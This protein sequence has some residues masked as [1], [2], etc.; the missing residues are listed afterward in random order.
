MRVLLLVPAL[1]L[2][3]TCTDVAPLTSTG[4][5]TP[6]YQAQRE[7]QLAVVK[8]RSATL[9]W[10]RSMCHNNR[11]ALPVRRLLPRVKT[12]ISPTRPRR[13]WPS[14][15]AKT[16]P[17][18]RRFPWRTLAR[19]RMNRILPP[20]PNAAASKPT[21]SESSRTARRMSSWPRR[22]CP[23]VPRAARQTLCNTR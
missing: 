9:C 11:W 16:Q 2:A 23:S 7:A 8:V 5:N 17:R 20:C 14:H 18:L 3:A 4:F 15:L 10:L 13:H 1:T 6:E 12:R 19:F 21:P 22:Q